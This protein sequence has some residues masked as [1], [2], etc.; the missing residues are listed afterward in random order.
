M[1]EGILYGGVDAGSIA[2]AYCIFF[3]VIESLR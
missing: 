3:A 1:L 2:K